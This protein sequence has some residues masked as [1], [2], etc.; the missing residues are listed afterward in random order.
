MEGYCPLVED[1]LAFAA[2]HYGHGFVYFG[3]LIHHPDSFFEG[4][5][6]VCLRLNRILHQCVILYLTISFGLK[7][8]I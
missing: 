2:S 3:D 1:R 6:R 5:C 7:T 4:V 8:W